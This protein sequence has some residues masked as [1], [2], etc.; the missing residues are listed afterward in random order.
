MAISITDYLIDHAEV[1]WAKALANWS[2]LLPTEVTVWLVNRFGDLFLVFS[3]GAVYM[4]DVGAGTLVKVADS[5]DGFCSMIDEEDNAADWL[6]IPLVNQ[7]TAVGRLLQPGQCYGFVTLPVLGG[8][9][10]VENVRQISVD[11]YLRVCGIIHEQLRD[12]PDG[13]QV[14]LRVSDNFNAPP[15]GIE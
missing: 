9:Y 15:R 8:Q 14:V 11:E 3:E 10:S 12:V 5:R 4:L 13:T 7:L 2:W 6:M 1:D